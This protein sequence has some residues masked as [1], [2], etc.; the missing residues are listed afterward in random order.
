MILISHSLLQFTGPTFFKPSYKYD[1]SLI[2]IDCDC[3]MFVSGKGYYKYNTN[4]VKN[5][6][7]VNETIN[8]Y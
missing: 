3:H 8:L 5:G 2:D 6:E 4:P 1:H 7:Y